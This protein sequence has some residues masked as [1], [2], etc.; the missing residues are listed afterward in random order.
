ME[1]GKEVKLDSQLLHGFLTQGRLFFPG[2]KKG[3]CWKP[4]GLCYPLGWGLMGMG[5]GWDGMSSRRAKGLERGQNFS[6]HSRESHHM[7]PVLGTVVIYFLVF[8]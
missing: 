1:A 5:L 3:G 8:T 4:P 2:K 6:E 7:K